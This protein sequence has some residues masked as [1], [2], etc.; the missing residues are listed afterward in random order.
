MILKQSLY[1]QDFYAW[2]NEQ[3]QA[4]AQHQ[5]KPLDWEHLAQELIS[6]GIREKNEIKNRLVILFAHLLTWFYST[7]QLL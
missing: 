7:T 1:E 2:V 5:I 3:A 6:M 4:L